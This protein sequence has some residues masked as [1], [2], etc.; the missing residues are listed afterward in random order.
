MVSDGV[1]MINQYNFTS[2]PEQEV[3]AVGGY[4]WRK[5]LEAMANVNNVLEYAPSL[6]NAFPNQKAEIEQVQAQALFMSTLPFRP[7]QGLRTAL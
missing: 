4:I 1:E 5:V 2:D 7:L 6:I 3:G